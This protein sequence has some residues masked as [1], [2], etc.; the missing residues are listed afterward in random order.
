MKPLKK[1]ERLRQDFEGE[2]RKH[3]TRLADKLDKTQQ[4]VE[5][6]KE[7]KVKGS[8]MKSLDRFTRL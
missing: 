2:K 6:L 3:L 4:N 8:F 1:H 5:K 7:M